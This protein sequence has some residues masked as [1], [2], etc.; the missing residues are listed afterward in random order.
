MVDS[1]ISNVIFMLLLSMCN[2]RKE[3]FKSISIL[4]TG[5]FEAQKGE[6]FFLNSAN[7]LYLDILKGLNLPSKN[8]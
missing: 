2:K 1:K 5:N 3:K 4:N 8:Q 7:I 6:I